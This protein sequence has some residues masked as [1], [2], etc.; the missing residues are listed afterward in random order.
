MA[1]SPPGEKTSSLNNEFYCNSFTKCPVQSRES[2]EWPTAVS[3]KWCMLISEAGYKSG[4][5][6]GGITYMYMTQ[7]FELTQNHDVARRRRSATDFHVCV[8]QLKPRIYM[9]RILTL[10]CHVQRHPYIADPFLSATCLSRK[11]QFRI[12]VQKETLWPLVRER[13]IPTVRPSLVDEKF[14]ANFCG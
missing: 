8:I 13:N 7:L 4:P 14:S 6:S 1:L 12:L 9:D 2:A 11:A 10:V 5:D 3:P